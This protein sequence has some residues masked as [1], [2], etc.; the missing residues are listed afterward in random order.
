MKVII[1]T[2]QMLAMIKHLSLTF[3][4]TLLTIIG[5]TASAQVAPAGLTVIQSPPGVYY[6]FYADSSQPNRSQFFY[7]NYGTHQFDAVVPTVSSSV[8]NVTLNLTGDTKA[9]TTTDAS[10]NYIFSSLATFGS[11]D[12]TP[13]KAARTP[14]SAGINTVDVIAVQRHFLNL[15]TPLSGCRLMAADVNGDSVITSVD[16]I[17]IRQFF[18]GRSTGIANTGKYKFI[19]VS[20][21][22][23]GIVSDQTGQDFDT[24]VFGDVAA[25][26]AE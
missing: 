20:R 19:P 11:Y 25:P 12:V 14:G 8:P 22:Y 23:L 16:V 15:G 4:L 7:L 5:R 9:S 17:A 1:R 2:T 13:S 6:V 3:C 26:F 10:G 21:S 24:L 18:L